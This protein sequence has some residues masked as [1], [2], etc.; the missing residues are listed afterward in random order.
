[1][2]GATVAMG[3]MT[4]VKAREPQA[5]GSHYEEDLHM[6]TIITGESA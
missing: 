3:Q 4:H 5:P 2:L 6:K 1:M